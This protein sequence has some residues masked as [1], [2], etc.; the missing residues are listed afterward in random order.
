MPKGLSIAICTYNGAARIHQ[1]LEP[2]INVQL[3]FDWELLVIDNNSSDN[4]KTATSPYIKRL[5]IG[6]IKETRQGLIYAR[7]KAV[8]VS[9][10]DYLLFCDDDNA[11]N[12]N[13]LLRGFEIMEKNPGVGVLAGKGEAVFETSKP[14]WF[15]RHKNFYAVGSLGRINGKQEEG[16]LVYGAGLI[17]RRE[18]LNKLKSLG[19]QNRLLGR[20]GNSLSGGEDLELT[21]GVMNLGYEYW[22]DEKLV[23]QHFIEAHRLS[24]DYYLKLS[25]AIALSFPLIESYKVH[26]FENAKELKRTLLKNQWRLI[27]RMI[28]LALKWIKYR[29]QI[30]SAQLR[31]HWYQFFAFFRNIQAT[32]QNFERL[33]FSVFSKAEK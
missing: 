17:F 5:P 3:P 26:R 2:L 11:L 31:Y 25:K 9:Q 28:L 23:F 4:L 18:A 30:Y 13:Y 21:W 24:W 7:W 32:L 12:Q 22:Y 29:N 14:D 10:F 33:K 15:E 1:A 20:A 27:N 8:E 6:L 16:D 19:F